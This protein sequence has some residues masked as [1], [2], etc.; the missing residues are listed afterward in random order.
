MEDATVTRPQIVREE[1]RVVACLIIMCR[2]VRF[3]L[4]V[5]DVV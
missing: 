4:K 2:F 3:L 1:I 5:I